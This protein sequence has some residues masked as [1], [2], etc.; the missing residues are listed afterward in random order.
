[1][2]KGCY[3]ENMSNNGQIPIKAKDA[4]VWVVQRQ[5]GTDAPNYYKTGDFK[6]FSRL[7]NFQP[8]TGFNWL[9]QELHTYQHLDGKYGQG[10][11]FKPENF[12]STKKYPV[13]IIFYQTFSTA[14]YQFRVPSLN[15]TVITPGQSPAWFLNNGYLVFTP[16]IYV[17][18][19]KYGPTA[20]NVIEGAARYLK[21]L[22]FVDSNKLGCGS[23]SWSA[24]LGA[25][26][27]T[28]SKSIA[29]TAISEGMSYGDM[30]N[31]AFSPNKEGNRLEA[32]ENERGSGSLWQNKE[33]WLDQTTVLNVDQVN[34][35]LLLFCNKESSEDYQDQTFQFFNALKRLDKNVWW[36]KYDKGRHTLDDPDEIRDFTIRYTQYFDHYLKYS[37]APKWMTQGI[38]VKLKGIE[39]R[40]ELDPQ[41]RCSLNGKDDCPICKAW[42]EQYKRTPG[43]FLKEIND[44]VLDK[45]IAME[46][47]QKIKEK[48]AAR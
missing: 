32:V 41:G 27:F 43:M 44:W 5:S 3:D 23:H 36:L 30:F 33:S 17:A 8:Q 40:Y 47:E 39:S 20:F 37:P 29:A 48:K 4:T 26:I 18:P 16:D 2:I 14:L 38:P 46:L 13:V 31:F 22:P 10:V 45:D 34:G 15:R 25:Y 1:M 12:D 35:P 9:T 21:K 6:S 7:T 42:N 24:Q 28:H 19:L 11:L